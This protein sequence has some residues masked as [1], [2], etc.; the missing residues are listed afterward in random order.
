MVVY[1]S[2]VIF[3]STDDDNMKSRAHVPD[4]NVAYEWKEGRNSKED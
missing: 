2:V 4:T 3:F 1:F